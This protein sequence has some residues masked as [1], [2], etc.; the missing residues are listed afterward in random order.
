[1]ADN[2]VRI[3]R[4]LATTSSTIDYK[5]DST[6]NLSVKGTLFTN[7][8]YELDDEE[9]TIGS[10]LAEIPF[11]INLPINDINKNDEYSPLLNPI[12]YSPFDI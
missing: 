10:V 9:H 6:D 4:V 7:V 11:N 8:I 12:G 3:D 5:I 1:M 2:S